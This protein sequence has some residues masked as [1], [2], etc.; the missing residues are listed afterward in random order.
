MIPEE[1]SM[2]ERVKSASQEDVRKP[3]DFFDTRLDRDSM[4]VLLRW[5]AEGGTLEEIYGHTMRPAEPE[6]KNL[7]ICGQEYLAMC[8][9]YAVRQQSAS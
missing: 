9:E 6:L 4:E 1:R 7:G 5:A 8:M 2:L 3:W